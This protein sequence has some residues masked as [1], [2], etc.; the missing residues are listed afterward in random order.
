M[1]IAALIVAVRKNYKKIIKSGTRLVI[2]SCIAFELESHSLVVIP[3]YFPT[4]D[5]SAAAKDGFL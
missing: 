3:A 2:G 1:D 5:A 4:D